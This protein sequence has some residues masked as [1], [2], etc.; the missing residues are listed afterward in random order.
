MD[1]HGFAWIRHGSGMDS[2]WRCSLAALEPPPASA[3]GPQLIGRVTRNPCQIHAGL[4]PNPRQ[5]A[6]KPCTPK[7]SNSSCSRPCQICSGS[8]CSG[9][10]CP[11]IAHARAGVDFYCFS[12]D[13][14]NCSGLCMDFLRMS[15]L[16]GL[17]KLPAR[18]LLSG[19]LLG[20]VKLPTHGFPAREPRWFYISCPQGQ[21]HMH[22]ILL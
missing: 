22:Y 10:G 17:V 20:L 13:T 1:S 3:G 16:L 19:L 2:A 11:C 9:W 12:L 8:R 7:A 4:S 14:V 21:D 18:G 15:L 6:I 5:S